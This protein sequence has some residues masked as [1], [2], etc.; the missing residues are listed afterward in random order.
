MTA[1]L[2]LNKELYMSTTGKTYHE[3]EIG[4]TASFSK[5][6]TE[7]D[8]SFY[9]SISG[10]FN[11]IHTNEEYASTTPFQKRI[12][13]G[14]VALSFVGG[15]LGSHLPGQGTIFLEMRSTF[16]KPVYIHDTITCTATVKKKL[17][18]LKAVIFSVVWKNQRKELVIR[19]ECKVLPP[20]K[21]AKS[22]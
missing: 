2:R 16:K 13:H 1:Q 14:G 9:S 19:G 15:I 6:I 11:L 22:N 10:D 21:S 18:R 3:I 7:T 17:D 12:A 4:D 5:T 20:E 8:I